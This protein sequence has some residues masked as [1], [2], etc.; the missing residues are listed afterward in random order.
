MIEVEYSDR[1][2]SVLSELD[3]DFITFHADQFTSNYLDADQ[4]ECFKRGVEICAKAIKRGLRIFTAQFTG[5]D[6]SCT[7]MAYVLAKTEAD[8]L[9]RVAR[10]K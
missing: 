2:E 6:D 1:L 3:R 5:G 10:W 8:A 7:L 9:K 4:E